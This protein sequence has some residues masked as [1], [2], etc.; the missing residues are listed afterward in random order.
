MRPRNSPPRSSLRS[1]MGEVQATQMEVGLK[2][3]VFGTHSRSVQQW[4]IW[5]ATF[6]PLAESGYPARIWY[7][8]AWVCV[9]AMCAVR[10]EPHTNTAWVCVG[11]MCVVRAEPHTNKYL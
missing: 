7:V 10:A 8:H 2:E 11:A 6:S 4:D 3:L 9:G 1:P 5:E